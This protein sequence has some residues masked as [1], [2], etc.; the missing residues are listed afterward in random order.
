MLSDE[1]AR[2]SN[3]CYQTCL[4]LHVGPICIYWFNQFVCPFSTA[5]KLSEVMFSFLIR[6]FPHI[7][8]ENKID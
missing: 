3:K 5:S 8:C 6:V 2:N 4:Q 1:I 7:T